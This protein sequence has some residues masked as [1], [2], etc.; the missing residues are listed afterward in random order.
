M[1][2]PLRR[3]SMLPSRRLT[4]ILARFAVSPVT[5]ARMSAKAFGHPAQFDSFVHAPLRPSHVEVDLDR[6]RRNFE[7]IEAQKPGD[8]GIVAVVKDEAYG[9]GAIEVASIAL[10][11]GAK[12]LAVT[13]LDEAIA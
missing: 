2:Q 5:T 12:F 4:R 8:V 9:H 7:L 10:S 11:T 1:S 13:I 6:L 3:N